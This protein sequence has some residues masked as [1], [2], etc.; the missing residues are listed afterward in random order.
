MRFNEFPCDVE[1]HGDPPFQAALSEL[2]RNRITGQQSMEER[3]PNLLVGILVVPRRVVER[4][5]KLFAVKL[6]RF[7]IHELVYKRAHGIVVC[8]GEFV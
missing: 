3:L 5:Q 7:R 4:A 8:N 6:A 1:I 2:E